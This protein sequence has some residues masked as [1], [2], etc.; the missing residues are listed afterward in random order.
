MPDGDDYR[1]KIEAY[2]PDTMPMERLA[3]YLAELALMLGE[4]KSVHFV[5]LEPGSTSIIHRI[6]TEAIPKV[7]AR[8]ASVRRGVGP[9]DSVRAY[10][11]INK[12]L[13]E[14]NGRA[15]WKAETSEAE[16]IVFPGKEDV[17][18]Q[19]TGISQRGSIDGEVVR[20]GGLQSVVPIM[21]RCEQQELSGCWAKRA[22]AKNLAKRLFEPVR[23][24]GTG[25]WNRNDEGNWKLDI[26]RVESFEP[27]RDVPLS[28]A[29]N[30]LRALPVDWNEASFKELG[31]IRGDG[32]ES[33]NGGI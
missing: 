18:L 32:G 13:R 14:D 17:E 9:R 8:T 23:L 25:R 5:K 29:L 20:I 33:M 21:L 22:V 7:K 26:F 28:K 19:V 12:M 2:T 31:L 15:V 16:I 24:F 10:R 11:K 30:E 6:E 27:L 1:L 4:N 3:E